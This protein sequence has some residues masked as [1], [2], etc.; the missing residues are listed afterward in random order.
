MKKN[1][2]KQKLD[3]CEGVNNQNC[4]KYTLLKYR[5]IV[6]DQWD[7]KSC[8]LFQSNWY[9]IFLGGDIHK[10]WALGVVF[11]DAVSIVQDSLSLRLQTKYSMFIYIYNMYIL[12]T[13]INA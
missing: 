10:G 11:F 8:F 4:Y 1:D 13:W 9:M 7:D 12:Y 3:D 5:T 6:W 2:S